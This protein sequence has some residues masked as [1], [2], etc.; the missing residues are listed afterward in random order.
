[1]GTHN[2]RKAWP[3]SPAQTQHKRIQGT[4]VT[5]M[6]P[7][8]CGCVLC[9][10]ALSNVLWPCPTPCPMS[11]VTLSHGPV[12]SPIALSH[13]PDPHETVR[14]KANGKPTM[15][16]GMASRGGPFG[17]MLEPTSHMSI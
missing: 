17:T 14:G 6:Y 12:L 2:G 4:F 8:Y 1:M 15:A 7:T 13:V 11:Y 9:P 10:M 3:N 16:N 5:P